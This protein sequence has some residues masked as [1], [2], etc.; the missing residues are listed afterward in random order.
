MR[1]PREFYSMDTKKVAREILVKILVH[2]TEQG[3]LKGK[4][5]EAEAYLGLNDPSMLS[6]MYSRNISGSFLIGSTS[7]HLE[8]DL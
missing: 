7:A 6:R 2:R 5:V 4:K 3:V 8:F 1:L